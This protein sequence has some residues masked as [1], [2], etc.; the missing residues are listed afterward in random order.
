MR[1]GN[2]SGYPAIR[3][4]RKA[5]GIREGSMAA[6]PKTVRRIA[7]PWGITIGTGTIATLGVIFTLLAGWSA[8]L[9]LMVSSG[10]DVS[11]RLIEQQTEMQFIYERQ[12]LAVRA[13]LE[14]MAG[15]LND[16]PETQ[17]PAAPAAGAP[18][19]PL[20]ADT[21]ARLN[22]IAQRQQRIEFRHQLLNT[23]QSVT[24]QFDLA[25]QAPGA[26][27]PPL[28]A[29]PSPPSPPVKQ[30]RSSLTPPGGQPAG[31]P[32]APLA[33]QLQASYMAP[34]LA[35]ADR[36]Y[37]LE[38]SMFMVET[39]Q[40]QGMGSLAQR[41]RDR[42]TQVRLALADVGINADDPSG[43]GAKGLPQLPMPVI[44]TSV[45]AAGNAFVYHM[46]QL[47][48]ALGQ[49]ARL[50][51]MAGSMPFFRPVAANE[52][53]LTSPFGMRTHPILG[54]QRLHA[55]MDFGA[56][57]GTPIRSPAN[58]AVSFASYAGGAGN[59]VIVDHGNNVRTRFLH[60]DEI[61]V[62]PGQSVTTG[63]LLGKVGT[64]GLSTGPH[65]HY[66]AYVNGEPQDPMKFIRAG[67]R[68]FTTQAR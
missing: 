59:M 16:T 53:R 11:E 20:S 43:K 37:R 5:S 27:P 60:L 40:V 36:V 24:Q 21:E 55:G 49:F 15:A 66:E 42:I 61:S 67:E 28:L 35:P 22:G 32:A 14:Q 47:Q 23:M 41:A 63:T 48:Q 9:T 3:N 68:F 64:T 6:K 54:I 26:A 33:P 65:L 58:G 8:G 51:P 17:E 62:K 34:G 57:T 1:S 30:D 19:G 52:S 44:R 31:Q 39:Q 29:P 10:T 45:P 2:A 12:L 50:K 7:E 4:S 38:R 46:D 56:P 18:A 13:Q 25:P